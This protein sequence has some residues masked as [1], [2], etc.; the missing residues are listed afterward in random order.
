MHVVGLCAGT[1]DVKNVERAQRVS[2]FLMIDI[3][4]V[5]VARCHWAHGLRI[6]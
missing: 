4:N 3:T 6:Q 2:D 1:F 5:W